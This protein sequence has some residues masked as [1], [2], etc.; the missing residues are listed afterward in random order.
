MPAG[1]PGKHS[2][3]NRGGLSKGIT[4]NVFKPMVMITIEKNMQNATKLPPL[5]Y[6]SSMVTDTAWIQMAV[7]KGGEGRHLTTVLKLKV[8]GETKY[9]YLVNW[10]HGILSFRPSMWVPEQKPLLCSLSSSFFSQSGLSCRCSSTTH[11]WPFKVISCVV[12]CKEMC[13][14]SCAGFFAPHGAPMFP[15]S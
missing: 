3:K 9:G 12:D 10:P 14:E 7:L 5:G 8:M 2:H 4:M 6:Q 11:L 15:N 1:G 13:R